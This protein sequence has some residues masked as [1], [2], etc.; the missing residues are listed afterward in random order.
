MGRTR[1]ALAEPTRGDR[2]Q[3]KIDELFANNPSAKSPFYHLLPELSRLFGRYYF[4]LAITLFLVF[5]GGYGYHMGAPES[6]S[7]AAAAWNSWKF[8]ATQVAP[9]EAMCCS[10]TCV[11]RMIHQTSLSAPVLSRR[12]IACWSHAVPLNLRAGHILSGNGS[13]RH[14]VRADRRDYSG[15]SRGPEEGQ[16]F[17]A[18]GGAFGGLL[19]RATCDAL[20]AWFVAGNSG[21]E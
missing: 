12:W 21:V 13:L 9:D 19:P 18:R 11:G 8:V 20:D 2:F 3:Y 10:I 14:P 1:I 15:Q 5:V 4:L 7:Y 16:K 6:D 17:G